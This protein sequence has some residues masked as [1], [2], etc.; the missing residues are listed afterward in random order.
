MNTPEEI[1]KIVRSLR[2]NESL[3]SFAERCEVSHTTID[4]I[5]KG[6]DFRTGKPTNPSAF[7]LSKIAKAAKVSIEYIIGTETE[8]VTEIE[9]ALLEIFRKIPLESKP[10][11]LEMLRT[12]LKAAGIIEE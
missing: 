3:R 11:A 5:E 8:E 6:V 9:E 10:L 7:I 2:G 12:A 4:N 1:G